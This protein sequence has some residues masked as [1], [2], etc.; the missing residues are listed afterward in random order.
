MI[1]LF[2]IHFFHHLHFQ[3]YFA[4]MV[5]S[6]QHMRKIKEKLISKQ[7][8]AEKTEKVTKMRKMKKLGKKVS[9]FPF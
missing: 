9:V 5:K 1:N 8:V 3:D 2:N 4:E 6:D 7:L